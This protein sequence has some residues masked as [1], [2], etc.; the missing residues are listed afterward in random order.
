MD[1]YECLFS[2]LFVHA[3]GGNNIEDLASVDSL[4]SFPMLKV[5]FCVVAD[6]SFILLLSRQISFICIL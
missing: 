2:F 5:R 4:N 1:S 6:P 3:S